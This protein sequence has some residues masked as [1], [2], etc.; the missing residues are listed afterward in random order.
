MNLGQRCCPYWLFFKKI[1]ELFRFDLEV[2][3]KHDFDLLIAERGRGIL[4]YFE[5]IGKLF[6]NYSFEVADILTEFEI[7]AFILLREIKDSLC[8]FRMNLGSLLVV[9]F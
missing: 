2:F 1:E 4:E 8:D 6:R 9:G 5:Y 3:F 7:D